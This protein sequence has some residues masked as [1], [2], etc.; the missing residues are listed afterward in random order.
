MFYIKTIYSFI[1]KGNCKEK[2]F[3]RKAFSFIGSKI[4]NLKT[5]ISTNDCTSNISTNFNNNLNE[6]SN[7]SIIIDDKGENPSLKGINI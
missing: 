5:F 3:G 4:K 2:N 6:C 7:P 1:L